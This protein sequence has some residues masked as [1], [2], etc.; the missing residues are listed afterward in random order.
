VLTFFTDT[1]ES[2]PKAFVQGFYFGVIMHE[3]GHSLG[4]RHNF[5]ASTQP[6]PSGIPSSV[7]DYEP[8]FV[9]N[10]RQAPGS[11]DIAAI[12]LGYFGEK[13]RSDLA[14][15]TDEDLGSSYACN[16]GDLGDPAAFAAAS[17]INGIALLKNG[18]VALPSHV[19]KPMMG[20][21]RSL[22]SLADK[23]RWSVECEG[24]PRTLVAEVTEILSRAKEI[25]EPEMDASRIASFGGVA[26]D[27]L[28]KAFASYESARPAGELAKAPSSCAVAA[29]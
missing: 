11:Y 1:K 15:C 16:Q 9:A 22:Y 17:V 24:A 5:A 27:N 2:D 25:L 23:A 19:E 8:N 28:L 3:F 18:T 4:L 26:R 10:K 13:P 29:R 20:S 14:F 12:R 21:I 6:D 7:M